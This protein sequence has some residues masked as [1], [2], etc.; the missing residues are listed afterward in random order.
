[1]ISRVAAVLLL[2][3]YLCLLIFVMYTHK[4]LM[5]PAEEDNSSKPK[6]ITQGK[7]GDIEIVVQP[8]KRNSGKVEMALAPLESHENHQHGMTS[9]QAMED[10]EEEK[11][12]TDTKNDGDDDDDLN[13]SLFGSMA[14]LFTS[15]TLVALLSEYLVGAIEPMSAHA[16]ITEAFIGLILVPII[17]LLFVFCNAVEHITAIRMARKGKMDISLSIA[18]GSATQVAMFVV[19]LAVIVGWMMDIPMT[20]DFPQFELIMFIYTSIIVFALVSN[21]S[22]NWLKGAM[23]LCLYVLIAVAVYHQKLITILFVLCFFC[24][25]SMQFFFPLFFLLRTIV[26]VSTCIASKPIPAQNI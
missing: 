21:G 16:G 8:S 17:G 4:H 19:G 1:M 12:E 5:E 25:V 24:S 13:M 7:T 9:F 20:L 22:S 6:A 10:T 2:V 26:V 14:L 15:T 3:M 18:I 23:L 11:E